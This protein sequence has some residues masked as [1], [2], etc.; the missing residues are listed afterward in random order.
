MENSQNKN[1]GTGLNRR[2]LFKTGIVLA[3]G[4]MLPGGCKTSATAAG[5]TTIQLNSK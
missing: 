3:G 2:D 1:A 4:A 5:G